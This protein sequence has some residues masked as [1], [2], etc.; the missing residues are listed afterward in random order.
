MD[1]KDHELGGYGM[2]SSKTRRWSY[3]GL[4]FIGVVLGILFASNMNWTTSGLANRNMSPVILGSQEPIQ[5]ELLSLQ[6]TS[7][8]FTIISKEILPTVVSISTSRIIRRSESDNL[9]DDPIFRD[10]FGRKFLPQQPEAQKQ[11]GLGSGVIVSNDGY[12][13]TN[14]HVIANADDI[15]VTLYDNRTFDAELVGTDPLTEVAVIKID[16]KDLPCARLGDSE[17]IEVGEWVLA[18]GN[19]L[20]L[21]STVTA[22]IIS[23]KGRA[24]GIIKDNDRDRS[25]GS[26]AIENFL[27]TDAAINPGNS[28]GALVNLKSEVIGINTAIATRTGGYQGYGFAVPINLAKKIMNDLISQGYVTRAWLGI[29]MKSVDELVAKR[30]DMEV[31]RGVIVEQVL[32]DSPA[33]KAGLKALDIILKLEEKAI[34]QSNEIQNIIALK[35]PGETITL[36]ILRDGKEK[37]IRVKLGQRDTGKEMV[38]RDE[39]E[40]GLPVLG[41]T[42]QTL[43]DDIRSRLEYYQDDEGA[44][45]VKVEPYSAA[46]D[47]RIQERDLVV[48]IEDI[49]ITSASDYRNTLKKFNKGDVIIV[50]LKRQDLEFHAFV[51]LPK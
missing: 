30:F 4:I 18:V 31:P 11:Q 36:L 22:G 42:V 10:F 12:I 26:Y 25:G 37:S 33:Q 15:R 41:L 27:Q 1:H 40:H 13:L 24:I 46:W 51:K 45:V 3:A 7:K 2:L 38:S 20:A 39:E 9:F 17:E 43:T 35:N 32:D 28:G 23:A 19:P 29:A 6:N 5:E 14:N 16:G 48:R 47:A 21:N 50:Y 8:A 49:K 44:I 34:R